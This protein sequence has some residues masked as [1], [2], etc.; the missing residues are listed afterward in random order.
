M[1]ILENEHI[2]ASFVAKGA[3]LQQLKSKETGLSYLWNGDPAFW[4]KHSPI[5]FP[6]I[7][8]L[9][10]SEYT[11]AGAHYVLP[12]H[13]FARDHEF[14]SEQISETELLFTLSQTD[15]TLA[16]YPFDFVLG[17]RYK[18]SGATLSCTYEVSNPGTKDLL[19]S[20]G[21]HP[22]FTAPLSSDLRYEDCY[23]EFNQDTELVYH[24]ITS[25]LIDDETKTIALRDQKL[26]LTHELFYEDA[27]VFKTLKSDC[28]SIK[29][30]KNSH[31]LDFNFYDFPFFGIWAAKDADFVCLEPWCGVAD[32]VHHDK[33]LRD[34]EGIIK[35]A[36][37]D[38]WNRTWSVKVY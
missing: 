14:V 35:L 18:I 2:T 6:V 13:G 27:L 20:I 32:G 11:Y 15:E 36:P 9:K 1:I 5:L 16:V 28:I 34:K 23:L 30:T 3:E 17:L 26:P 22:A 10:D 8:A 31:G 38:D 25:D 24:K 4:P 12:R 37:E 33:E 7:G 21:G 19:F 29:N